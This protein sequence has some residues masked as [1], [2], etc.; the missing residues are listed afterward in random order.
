MEPTIIYEDKDLIVINK[1]AGLA[2]HAGGSIKEGEALTAWLVKKFPEIKNIGDDPALRPGIV[3]RLDKETS[4]VMVV[5]RNQESFEILKQLFK[6]RQVE[7]RYIVLVQGVVAEKSGVI[8]LSIGMLRGNGV[9]RTTREKFGKEMKDAITE[10]RVLERFQN[11]TLVEARPKT[12]RMHQIRAHFAAL[13]HSVVG[14]RLY[15]KNGVKPE[16]PGRQFLHAGSLSFSYPGGRRFVFEA[17]L[18]Q[19]LKSFLA[20]LR[21]GR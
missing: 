11:A 10:F 4:G 6:T 19:D 15:G 8:K 13:H 3:H 17:A 21:K 5:A 12:G 16:G 7:K 14:D 18:P 9:K 1:P 20:L 2:V